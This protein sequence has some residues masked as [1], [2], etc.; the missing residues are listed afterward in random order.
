MKF[1]GIF[2][3]PARYLKNT[4][5]P[6]ADYM[7]PDDPYIKLNYLDSM[8]QMCMSMKKGDFPKIKPYVLCICKPRL[9]VRKVKGERS[10]HEDKYLLSLAANRIKPKEESEKVAPLPADASATIVQ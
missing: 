7:M 5:I 9:H 8:A 6:A 2:S 1:D 3:Q 4:W 10:W